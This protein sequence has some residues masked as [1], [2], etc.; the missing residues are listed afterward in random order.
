[1]KQFL[2]LLVITF[3]LT[4]PV[5]SQVSSGNHLIV[6][7]VAQDGGYPH[8]GCQKECCDRAW[9]DSELKRYVVSL[10]LAD[11]VAQKWYLFEATPDIKEQLQLFRSITGAQYNY[12]PDAI[13]V[14]H[15]HIGHYTGLFQFGRESM[16]TLGLP[17]YV[18]PRMKSFLEENGPWSQLVSLN[19]IFL[20]EV[21]DGGNISLAENINIKLLTVPHRDEFSETGGYLIDTDNIDYLFIPDIDKWE[22]W[23]KDIIGLVKTVD[24][25]FLDGTFCNIDEL[26]GREMSEIPHPFISETIN[27]FKLQN[28]ETKEKIHFIHFNHSNPVLWKDAENMVT[29]AGFN[30][31]I[32]GTKY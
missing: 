28:K 21:K 29:D 3:L 17:V 31:A 23:D 12:L 8:I 14:S 1:M 22:K 27:L 9:S 11:P 24:V 20:C 4:H 19:N 15:A 6:L 18:L 5:M 25:A 30:I 13:F 10:A 32:Q 26:S 7:G 16:N 2:L